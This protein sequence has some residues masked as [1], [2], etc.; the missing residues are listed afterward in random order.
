MTNGVYS[1]T[2]GFVNRS[3]SIERSTPSLDRVYDYVEGRHLNGVTWKDVSRALG[4]HHGQASGALSNLHRLGRVFVVAGEK[5]E[6]CQVYVVDK[7]RNAWDDDQRLDSPVITKAGR[8][9]I[10]V[11]DL[12]DTVRGF[13]NANQYLSPQEWRLKLSEALENYEKESK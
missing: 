4:I 6:R 11:I 8:R 10:A 2:Q 13:L 7:W 9:N 12:A 1:G 3:T 5:R